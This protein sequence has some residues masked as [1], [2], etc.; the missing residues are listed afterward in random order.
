MMGDPLGL[1][2]TMQPKALP[3]GFVTT[4]HRRGGPQTQAR[5]GM[6][7]FV[8]QM[9]CVTCGHGAF[10][11]W[12]TMAKGEAELPGFF[13][14]LEGHEQYGLMCVITHVQG[15]V[16]RYRHFLFELSA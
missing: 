13:T 14:Q 16:T 12:L 3:S 11:W 1:Q 10:A 6:G 15:E 9:L 2:K 5:F 7:H 8:E 4:D